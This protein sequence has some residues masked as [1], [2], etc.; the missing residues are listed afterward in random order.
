MKIYAINGSARKRGN[1]HTLIE[2]A[3]EPLREAGHDCEVISLA[4]LTVG[5]CTACALCRKHADGKCHGRDDD[6][7]PIIER[8]WDADA[9]ILASPTYFADITAE[10]KAFI[11]RVGYVN[12]GN[13]NPLSR[14]VGAALVTARRGGAIHA[15]DSISHLFTISDMVMVGSTYW[16]IAYGGAVGEVAQDDEGIRTAHRTGENVAWLLQKIGG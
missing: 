3:L 5:G 4:G 1:T 13:G 6:L 7:N 12:R 8:M 10:M 15:F 16:G 9:L 2:A 14:K 11:D